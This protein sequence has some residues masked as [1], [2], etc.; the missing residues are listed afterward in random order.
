MA[1]LNALARNPLVLAG[2]AIV[3]IGVAAGGYF[4][5][6]RSCRHVEQRRR[7]PPKRPAARGRLRGDA[8]IASQNFGITDPRP[9]S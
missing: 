1:D 4:L 3:V 7:P 5:G 8:S 6:T 2:S 9:R